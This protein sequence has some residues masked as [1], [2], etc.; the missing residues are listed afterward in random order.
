MRR[1][2]KA[3]L[4]ATRGR[5][6][7]RGTV[8]LTYHRV[9]GGSADE[10]DVTLDAFR[11]QMAELA[12]HEVVHLDTALDRLAQGDDSPRVVLTFDDGFRDV[13]DHAWPVLRHHG[14]PF[15]LY[16]STAYVGQTM[17]WPGSTAQAPG[18]ALTWEMVRDMVDSGLC[19]VGNHTHHHVRATDLEARELEECSSCIRD[20]TGREARHFAYPWGVTTPQAQGLV[21]SRFRSAATGRI[22]RNVPDTD[23]HAL[24]RVPVRGTDPFSFF[25]AKLH[26]RLGPEQ[27]YGGVV[28]VAKSVGMHA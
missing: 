16:L 25:R 18:P 22:G 1:Q 15:T 17:H 23:P 7:G 5:G 24:R 13:F 12:R 19:T 6:L 3:V 27:V 28:R 11:Q 10:R 2:V 21:A 9:G 4:G 8:L 26:G 14:L 20:Q